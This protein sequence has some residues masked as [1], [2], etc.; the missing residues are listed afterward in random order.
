MLKLF[1]NTVETIVVYLQ[2]Q[3]EVRN[4]KLSEMKRTEEKISNEINFSLNVITNWVKVILK[5]KQEKVCYF[6]NVF[7]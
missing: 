3:S 2:I 4:L 6:F 7:T 5:S 1:S